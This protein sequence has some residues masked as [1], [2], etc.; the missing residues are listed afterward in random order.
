[1]IGNAFGS[2]GNAGRAWVE[3]ADVQG[4]AAGNVGRRL[5]PA[6]VRKELEH[7]VDN[8]GEQASFGKFWKVSKDR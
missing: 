3:E 2:I 1:M 4:L 5:A 8:W 6:V 7:E